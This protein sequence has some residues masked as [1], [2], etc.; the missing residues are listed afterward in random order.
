MAAVVDLRAVQELLGRGA[1]LLE[2][3]PREEY[4]E[5]HLSGA[6]HIAL[7]ELDRERAG[8]AIDRD[9]PVIVYCWD[10]LCDMSPRAASVLAAFGYEPVDYAAG[11]V[12]WIAH[13]LPIEGSA[14]E[15]PTALRLLRR[16]VAT[17]ALEDPTA[18]VSARIERSPYGFALALATDDVVLGRVRRSR[19][20]EATGH[21]RVEEVMDPG[22][23]TIRPHT[24]VD[25]LAASVGA[26]PVQTLIVTDPEGRLL[27][28]VRRSDLEEPA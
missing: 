12:D 17:C 11:K 24:A 6:L 25:E 16:D 27:G 2:V 15:R 7:K 14:A 26:S 21:T 9:R 23:S 28:V 19:I 18:E 13:G 22:P 10:A 4:E 5:M 3:L 8:T 1:Q 20:A